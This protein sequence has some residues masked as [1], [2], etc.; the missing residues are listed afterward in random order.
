MRVP[1]QRQGAL[2]D[3]APPG[4][5]PRHRPLL[6]A[7]LFVVGFHPA[8]APLL[9]APQRPQPLGR[10]IGLPRRD[11]QGMLGQHQPLPSRRT[12]PT[13]PPASF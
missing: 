4:S 1:V 11:S 10:L 13:T 3:P 7:Q 9:G 5:L 8:Q 6:D 12:L 2:V